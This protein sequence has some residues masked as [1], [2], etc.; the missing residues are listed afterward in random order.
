M[1]KW[2]LKVGTQVDIKR[3]DG[4]YFSWCFSVHWGISLKRIGNWWFYGSFLWSS[5]SLLLISA[6]GR[7]HR[8][9]I[10]GINE[11]TETVTVEWFENEETKGKELDVRHIA[12][13]NADLAPAIT[14]GLAEKEQRHSQPSAPMARPKIPVAN[15]APPAQQAPRPPPDFLDDD[16]DDEDDLQ[17]DYAGGRGGAGGAGVPPAA[18]PKRKAEKPAKASVPAVSAAAGGAKK[19]GV[20]AEVQKIAENRENRR[21]QQ[22]ERREDMAFRGGVGAAAEFAEMIEN[23]REGIQIT[24]LSPSGAVKENRISV[25]VRKRP[26][27][28]KERGNGEADVITI[29]D[30]EITMVHEPKTKVDLTKYLE[31]HQFRFDYSFDEGVDNTTVYHYTARP[32]VKTIFEQGMATCFAYGQVRSRTVE[33]VECC[34][35][36]NVFLT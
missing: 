20:V 8:A 24:H 1:E 18:V 27:N 7:V 25:C 29:P 22:V 32:L 9:V 36:K 21:K 13:L 2:G 30:G 3:S 33:E 16:D 23:F 12:A 31:N 17:F 11:Q 5:C 14:R 28:G 6:P 10:S 34:Q 15:A 35:K 26:L 19:G 4:E